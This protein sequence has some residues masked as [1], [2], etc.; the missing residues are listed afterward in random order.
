LARSFFVFFLLAAP[1]FSSANADMRET[2]LQTA[3][4][5][6]LWQ[7]PYWRKLLYYE[8]HL[9]G[10]T[11]SVNTLPAFFLSPVGRANPEAEFNAE[12]DGL[13]Y[14]GS[15]DNDSPECRFP[16]RYDWLRKKLPVDSAALPLKNCTDFNEWKAGLDPQSVSLLFAAG[17][18]NNPS[19]LYGHTFLRLHKRGAQG[20]DLLDYTINYAAAAGEQTGVLFAIKG[21]IGAYPGQFST[22]PYYIKIQQYHNLEDRDLW[23]FPLTLSPDETD[24]LLRHGW[25]LGKVRFP[26]LFFTRNCA[27]QLLP[28]LEIAKP[29]LE[30][31]DKL[32]AWV[33]PSDSA[34]VAAAAFPPAEP[35]WRPSLW[36]TVNW[37]RTQLSPEERSLVLT[38]ARGNQQEGTE[39]LSLLPP[40]RQAAVLETTADYL[41][42]RMYARKISKTELDGRSDPLLLL[43]AKLGPQNTF[44]GGPE[45]PL[46]I[47]K[48]HES[49]RTGIGL[50]TVK[51]AGPAYELQ[52]RSAVQDVLDPPEGYLPDAALE[53]TALRM[54]YAPRQDRFY[55]KEARL[56]HVMSLNPWDDWVRRK[57]W[58][59]NAGLEQAD[60]TGRQAGT[61]AIAAFNAGSG[62]AA[63]TH[64]GARELFYALA[65]ADTGIGPT[66]D[67]NWRIGGGLKTGVLLEAGALR[68]LA[69]TRY[70]GYA[71]GDKT[72]L[73]CGTVTAA[74][75]LTL[76]NSIRLEYGWRGEEREA[77]IYL[78][79]FSLPPW[80]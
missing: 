48:A 68:A 15:N 40:P 11:R 34:K 55:F 47:T 49:M 52:W 14:S 7:S 1:A 32:P 25:E 5:R 57:S 46:P 76:N 54:R 78:Q 18:L 56:V 79:H 39:K 64:I 71:L 77:G 37:K 24:R 4:D 2:L 10:G 3:R 50:A 33:I 61:S 19:T 16:E 13:F 27:W 38:L 66:L 26:Y 53:M 6:R 75:H 17:Y 20:A 12:I 58:E 60:E 21:L 29:S 72:P 30:L 31:A 23:E 65:V 74:L 59:V 70:L 43:R 62:L 73:W 51:G 8:H 67:K 35:I 42:W 45:K 63:E 22:I 69:E 80:P 28:Y 41:S 44:T 9:F 36:K